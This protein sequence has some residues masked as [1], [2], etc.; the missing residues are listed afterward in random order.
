MRAIVW[1]EYGSPD[2]LRLA[3]VDKPTPKPGQV[4]VRVRATTVAAGDSEV[5]RLNIPLMLRLP[6]R[7]YLG[8]LRPRRVI[9]GQELSGEIE[10]IGSAVKRFQAGDQVFAVTGPGF[11][12]Y[13]EYIALPENGGIAFKPA[14]MT[15]LEAAAAPTAGL[16]ALYHLGKANIQPD[17]Q[18]AI[19]GGGGSIGTFAIQ[20]AKAYGAQVTGVD[21]GSKLDTMR[22]VGADAVFDYTRDDFTSSGRT[23]DVIFDVMGMSP[24][25]RTVRSL[26]QHGYYLLANSNLPKKLRGLWTSGTSRRRV[27]FGTARQNA[28]DLDELQSL[29]EAGKIRS[30]IDRCY[31]L[32]EIA[33]A[34]RYV[35]SGRKK[36]SVVVL[37]AE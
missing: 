2:G 1:T 22:S 36:G 18:V 37:V 34:H 21:E 33:E 7:I 28:E 10:A 35:D 32:E 3:E 14:N 17:Q 26:N 25:S 30:V 20:L 15:Y 5:R 23:Y 12:A 11:G 29:I 31:P 4:L 6:F 16:E 19:V 24:F 8:L 13:A 27:L 9:L